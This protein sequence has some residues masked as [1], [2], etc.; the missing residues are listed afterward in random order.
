MSWKSKLQE[1]GLDSLKVKTSFLEADI[2]L[3]ND[4][5]E[6]AWK[7][8]VELLTRI[9]TQALPTGSGDEKSALDSIYSL[10]KTTRRVLKEQGQECIE[11]TKLAVIVLN[12]IVRPFTAK[13][14]PKML[15]DAFECES[16]CK[17]FR[18]ELM[19][20]QKELRKYSRALADLAEVEDLTDLEDVE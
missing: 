7:L 5:R 2:S 8:Y 3:K 18:K 15:A 11:F 6:A 9:T 1:W 14:H 4:D 19:D 20:L 10:F 13:W 12:Q 16:E 17:V